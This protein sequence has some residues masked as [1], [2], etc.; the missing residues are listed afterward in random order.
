MIISPKCFFHFFK[1]LIFWVHHAHSK[2]LYT[3][4][5]YDACA[6]MSDIVVIKIMTSI[7]C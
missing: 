4:H 1:I 6:K 5:L 7:W 2:Q 3:E